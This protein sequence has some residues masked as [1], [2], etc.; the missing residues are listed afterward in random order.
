MKL[1][2]KKDLSEIIK[3]LEIRV[4][5]RD[6]SGRL[7]YDIFEFPS[8]DYTSMKKQIAKKFGLVPAGITIY[9]LDEMFQTYMK[10]L[11]RIGIEWD[12]WSGLIIVAK[13]KKA[14]PLVEEIGLYLEETV[15]L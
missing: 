15:K 7:T 3:R 9:G 2:S 8:E 11:K 6:Y 10:G 14:E 1:M 13:N 12:N 5:S 4:L